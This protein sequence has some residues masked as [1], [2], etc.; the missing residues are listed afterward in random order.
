LAPVTHCVPGLFLLVAGMPLIE[1]RRM[2]DRQAT[3]GRT[4]RKFRT[5]VRE[6]GACE[7]IVGRSDKPN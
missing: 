5:N 2:A 4:S 6:Q 7:R 3:D 1:R